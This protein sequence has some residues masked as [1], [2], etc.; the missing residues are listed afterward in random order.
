MKVVDMLK[1]LLDVLSN[2]DKTWEIRHLVDFITERGRTE[3]RRR[4]K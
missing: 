2:Y 4:G 3:S 1:S